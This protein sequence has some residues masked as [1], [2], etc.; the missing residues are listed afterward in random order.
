M[1]RTKGL[2]LIID[3]PDELATVCT[4][5]DK[6]KQILVYLADNAIKFTKSGSVRLGVTDTGNEV[7]FTVVDTGIGIAPENLTRVFQPF[8]QVNSGLTRR[9]GGIGLGLYIAERFAKLLRGYIE[10]ESTLERGSTF[11]LVIPRS[12]SR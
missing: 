8:M 5:R 3:T 2:E 1:A 9:Y 7:R 10:V 12:E 11:S 6:V 4:D